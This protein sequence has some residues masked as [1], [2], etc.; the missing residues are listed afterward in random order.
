MKIAHL[1]QYSL[2]MKKKLIRWLLKQLGYKPTKEICIAITCDASQA[3]SAIENVKIGFEKMAKLQKESGITT[4]GKI[5]K[6]Q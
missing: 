6:K 4:D 1:N 5:V 2:V 3:L